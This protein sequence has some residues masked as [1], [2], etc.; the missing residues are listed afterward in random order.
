MSLS[1]DSTVLTMPVQPANGYSNGFN[2]WGGDWMGWI[3]LFLIFGMFGW[4]GMGG[5]G[6]RIGVLHPQI[7][8]ECVGMD[9]MQAH[10]RQRRAGKIAQVDG[11]NDA[12]AAVQRGLDHMGVVGVGQ[13]QPDAAGAGFGGGGSGETLAQQGDFRACDAAQI[14]A[15]PGGGAAPFLQDARR[16]Q[17]AEQ[18]GLRDI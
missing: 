12:R 15:L 5:F 3:V 1:S 11:D 7:G 8:Q 18:T 4:G 10:C 9:G 17:G 2:G 14:L 6:H 16:P 13:V